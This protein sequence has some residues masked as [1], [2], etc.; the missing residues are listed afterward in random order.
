M[1]STNISKTIVMETIIKYFVNLFHDLDETDVDHRVKE[2]INKLNR[3]ERS[4]LRNELFERAKLIEQKDN[5]SSVLWLQKCFRIIDRYCYR[6]N[7]VYFSPGDEIKSSLANVLKEA[8]TSLDLCMF[9]ITHYELA[10]QIIACKKRKVTVRILTDDEKVLD[11][12][13]EINRLR[14][15]G[16]Q[17]KID[18]SKYHM[19]NKFGVIDKR[20]AFTGSFN[21]TYTATKHNQENLLV[22]SNYDIVRQYGEEFDRLWSEMFNL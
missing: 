20:V 17:V 2:K 6:F 1:G 21:W 8:K 10:K 22:T 7:K 5:G 19:H 4:E 18:N 9:T 14:D 3:N 16:I 13:S 12:G 15:A 11:R